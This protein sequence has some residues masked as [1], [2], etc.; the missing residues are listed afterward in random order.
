[1]F[2]VRPYKRT[3]VVG[4]RTATVPPLSNMYPKSV[5]LAQTG[6]FQLHNH[7]SSWNDR[8]R[9]SYMRAEAIGKIYGV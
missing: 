5:E 9:L 1:M 6:L 3:D 2:G 4:F 8:I 7:F